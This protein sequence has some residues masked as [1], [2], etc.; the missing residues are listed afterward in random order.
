[1][2][3]PES[4]LIKEYQLKL[5]ANDFK[6]GDL[7]ACRAALGSGKMMKKIFRL[8]SIICRSTS[9]IKLSKLF[10][11]RLIETFH[12]NSCWLDA[13]LPAVASRNYNWNATVNNVH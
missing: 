10:L 5:R 9:R 13:Y 7:N 1:M 2:V 8:V 6:R 12:L 3:T 4:P 11:E